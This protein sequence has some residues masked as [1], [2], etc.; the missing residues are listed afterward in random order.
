LLRL[1]NIAAKEAVGVPVQRAFEA[2][3]MI[4]WKES[5]I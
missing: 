1:E 4:V 5:T 2:D 3:V